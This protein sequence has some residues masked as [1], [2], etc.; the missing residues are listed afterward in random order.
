[1][2]PRIQLAALMAVAGAGVLLWAFFR[3]EA[4]KATAPAPTEISAPSQ[5]SKTAAR[6][7]TRPRPTPEAQPSDAL[8]TAMP[9]INAPSV[10]VAEEA[11]DAE[12]EQGPFEVSYGQHILFFNDPEENRVARAHVKLTVPDAATRAE[13]V[14][15]RKQLLRMLY[16]LATRRKAEPAQGPGGRRRFEV[17]YL[18]RI[19]NVIRG[20]PVLDVRFEDYSVGPKP[21]KDRLS[22]Q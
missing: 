2:S 21:D 10:Q 7:V 17:D 5:P 15:R 13:V 18:D 9:K 12:V 19:N 4:R 20:E 8:P 6:P 14:Q 16:F 22:D 11:P 3:P 1:M